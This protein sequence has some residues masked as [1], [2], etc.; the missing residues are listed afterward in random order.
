MAVEKI[1]DGSIYIEAATLADTNYLYHC[2]EG[3]CIPTVG[4]IV[5]G[6]GGSETLMK[7][8]SNGCSSTPASSEL[9]DSCADGS[10]GKIKLDTTIKSC[11]TGS[12]FTDVDNTKIY[13]VGSG[14]SYKKFVGN[15]VKNKK[16]ILIF[17]KNIINIKILNKK[18]LNNKNKFFFLLFFF[19]III[20]L[21]FGLILKKIY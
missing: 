1:V 21:F 7:C 8:S 12:D 5:V 20:I 11:I 2:R 4:Y 15:L 18:F 14:T 13:I 17:I 10:Y 19:F 6:S 16:N 3:D 9:V